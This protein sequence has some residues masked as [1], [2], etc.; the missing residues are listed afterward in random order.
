MTPVEGRY[1]ATTETLGDK[2]S[3]LGVIEQN[4]LETLAR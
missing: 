3:S 1:V 2:P 4:P